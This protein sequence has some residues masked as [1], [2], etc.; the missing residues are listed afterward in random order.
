MERAGEVQ[1]PRRWIRVRAEHGIRPR[2]RRTPTLT[3]N[4]L[5]AEGETIDVDDEPTPGFRRIGGTFDVIRV[6]AQLRAGGFDAQPDHVLF[7]HGMTCCCGPHPAA[8]F[9]PCYT[10][11]PLHANPLHANPL[12][13]NPLHANPLHANSFYANSADPNGPSRSSARPADRAELVPRASAS[14]RCGRRR[15]A[16]WCSTPVSP[17][18]AT[19]PTC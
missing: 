16:W 14:A 13:A 3:S 8:P 1:R 6:V 5:A 12:H 15:R 19:S 2:S 10:A 9:D 4:D 18:R 11:N 17:T 7:A